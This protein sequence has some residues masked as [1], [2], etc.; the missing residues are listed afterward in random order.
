MPIDY[1]KY[2]K[3]WKSEIR[4]A[5]LERA[6]NCCEQC[7][8]ENKSIGYRNKFGHFIAYQEIEDALERH[9][10]DYFEHELSHCYDARGNPTKAI[11]IVLTIAHLDHDITNNNYSNLKALCQRCHINLD[12]DQHRENAKKTINKKKGLQDLF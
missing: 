11:K 10:Y 6:K 12:K 4:P 9:G 7:E 1:A 8:V 2:P 5:I 3:N